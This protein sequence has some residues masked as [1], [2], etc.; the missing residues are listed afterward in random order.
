MAQAVGPGILDN[1]SGVI[2]RKKSLRPDKE[3]LQSAKGE[4]ESMSELIRNIE[5]GLVFEVANTVAIEKGKTNSLTLSRTPGCK[6]TI[7]A[8]DEGE[9]LSTHSASGDAM[10]FVLEGMAEMTLEGVT[11]EVSAGE[12]IILPA[13][14][15]H[16]VYAKTPFKMLLVV[17]K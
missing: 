13:D 3:S 12:A 1:T 6:M 14:I 11:S 7:F 16:A 10:A 2:L 17:V 9:G 4:E 8:I 15:P 5:H